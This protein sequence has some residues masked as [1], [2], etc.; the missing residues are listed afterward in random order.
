[1]GINR[2]SFEAAF[3]AL[4]L[5]PASLNVA[6]ESAPRITSGTGAPS[7]A[8]PDGST[9][10]RTDGAVATTIYQ[11]VSSAW[12]ALAPASYVATQLCT[13]TLAAGA[14]A[15]DVIAVTINVA[16]LGG[17]AVSRAQ[18]LVCSLYEATMIEAV[19]AAFTM[20]ETGAGTEISTT[21]NARLIIDTDANGDAI[22]SV[23][24]VAGASGKTMYLVVQPAPASGTNTYGAP[25]LLAITFD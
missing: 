4:R 22:I 17:T 1:M 13:V 12:Y 14:E 5:W 16:D 6:P 19:A 18:R 7:A 25:A 15:A 2:N 8:D 3:R 24:D 10:H 9:W 23:T 21:A 20:A 11:R